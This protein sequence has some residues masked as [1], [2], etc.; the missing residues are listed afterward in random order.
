MRVF[1]LR[2][3]G[4]PVSLK[5]TEFILV[6]TCIDGFLYRFKYVNSNNFI[7]DYKYY[8]DVD[9]KTKDRKQY[10]NYGG[11]SGYY[12]EAEYLKYIQDVGFDAPNIRKLL[13]KHTF[14]FD[15]YEATVKEPISVTSL[16]FDSKEYH[17]YYEKQDFLFEIEGTST[18]NTK[19]RKYKT[20]T[21]ENYTFSSYKV[22]IPESVVPSLSGDDF[23]TTPHGYFYT[24]NF[25]QK[26][27]EWN[28]IEDIEK[29]NIRRC[30][31]LTAFNISHIVVKIFDNIINQQSK[32]NIE[33]AANSNIQDP[34]YLTSLE[35]LIFT[36]KKCWGYFYIPGSST[37]QPHRHSFEPIFS[38]DPPIY[39]EY[40][41][42]YQSVFSFYNT[43]YRKIDLL[44]Q[45]TESERIT[46]LLTI[47]PESALH[48]IDDIKIIKKALAGIITK[49]PDVEKKKT[50]EADEQLIVKLVRSVKPEDADEF[51][52]FLLRA[53]NCK[54]SNFEVLYKNLD[55]ARL[56]R[57][58]GI[59][60]W[61]V[62]EETNKK[63]YAYMVYELWK[64][65]KY[66]ISYIPPGVT[67]IFSD[68]NPNSYFIENESE[69]L[70]LNNVL[71][72]TSTDLT[73]SY[74]I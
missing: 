31:T 58:I 14:K 9:F 67:P 71:V 32:N 10:E 69:K 62:K 22:F 40:Y 33:E 70:D 49:I 50:S 42:Y 3:D 48:L 72:F 28:K 61:F 55:D 41:T 24:K 23:L 19:P 21:V 37:D 34:I 17:K 54:N 65:S 53:E 1:I 73:N 18:D 6:N 59:S 52:D 36:L 74:N 7:I 47:L 60:T 30:I 2:T 46:Y 56:N 64:V 68:I 27:Y 35:Y 38:L 51:L 15:A 16:I 66:N 43:T 63:F 29:S 57:I 5:E 20:R 13:D 45:K 44:L 25:G 26:V 12:E 11:L 4:T 39:E 8:N